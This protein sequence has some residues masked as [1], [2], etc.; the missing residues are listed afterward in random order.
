[1]EI[2][3]KEKIEKENIPPKQPSSPEDLEVSLNETSELILD[4][5]KLLSESLN[6]SSFKLDVKSDLRMKNQTKKV[7]SP[8]I[9]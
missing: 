6:S 7:I 3:Q 8:V 9:N 4:E 1:M 5:S 2:P